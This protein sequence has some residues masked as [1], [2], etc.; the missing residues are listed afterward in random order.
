MVINYTTEKRA[1]EKGDRDKG[2]NLK[3]GRQGL[4]EKVT[5]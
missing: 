2:C 4:T 1:G 5:F 3:C